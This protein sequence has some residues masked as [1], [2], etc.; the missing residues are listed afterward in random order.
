MIKFSLEGK[1]Y[2]LPT[3]W[4]EVSFKTFIRVNKIQDTNQVLP[5]PEEMLLTALLEA[6][7]DVPEGSFDEMSYD[8]LLALSPELNNFQQDLPTTVATTWEIDGQI[9]SYRRDPYQYKVNEVADIRQIE[10]TKTNNYDWLIK[11]AAIMI[12][13]ANKVISEA[14]VE[15]YQLIKRNMVD[16]A[17]IEEV[18]ANMKAFEVMTVITFFLNGLRR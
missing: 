17:K 16:M 2:S 9:Y 3:K 12:R 10:A 5:L 7:C 8:Q 4:E 6:F 15:H 11:I 14:G 1:E 18:V 13:P